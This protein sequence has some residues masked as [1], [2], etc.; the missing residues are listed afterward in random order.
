MNIL[1]DLLAKWKENKD[2][3]ALINDGFLENQKAIQIS[4]DEKSET[5]K[6]DALKVLAEIAT[7]LAGH[8]S[9]LDVLKTEIKGQIEQNLKSAQACLS[10][11]SASGIEKK[12][13]DRN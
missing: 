8:I 6:N 1:N 13:R 4:L 9:E 5:E 7:A 2:V 12:G 3:E 10:Y 11:G